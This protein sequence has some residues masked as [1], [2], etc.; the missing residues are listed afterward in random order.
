[1]PP[2]RA[3]RMSSCLP[4]GAARAGR[5]RSRQGELPG[6]PRALSPPERGSSLLLHPPFDV[7]QQKT[8]SVREDGLR[9]FV[10]VTSVARREVRTWRSA[11]QRR[12]GRARQTETERQR[13]ETNSLR[14]HGD[15]GRRGSLPG[16]QSNDAHPA[17]SMIP[18]ECSRDGKGQ[19]QGV[20]GRSVSRSGCPG[21]GRRRRPL[22]AGTQ[23]LSN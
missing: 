19:G 8:F 9:V 2:V 23:F 7:P 1:M 16:T 4:H 17:G 3:S 12:A 15:A 10:A 14:S 5:D 22:P 21:S 18:V 11:L 20:G 6:R 13:Y